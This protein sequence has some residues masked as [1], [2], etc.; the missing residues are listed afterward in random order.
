L[1]FYLI[2][3]S[4]GQS[5]CRCDVSETLEGKPSKEKPSMVSNLVLRGASKVWDKTIDKL[6][7]K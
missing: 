4:S 7:G 5:S 2:G 6:L 1:V 3:Q